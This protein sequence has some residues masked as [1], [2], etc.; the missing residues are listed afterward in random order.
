[1]YVLVLIHDALAHQL[2]L[3]KFI[4]MI[5]FSVCHGWTC[6]HEILMRFCSNKLCKPN[7]SKVL[8]ASTDCGRFGLSSFWG[9]NCIAQVENPL[10]QFQKL[11]CWKLRHDEIA[12]S[13]FRRVCWRQLRFLYL[14]RVSWL[15]LCFLSF[16]RAYTFHLFIWNLFM[17]F[18]VF[19]FFILRFLL[20]FSMN[21]IL[22]ILLNIDL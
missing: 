20:N 14:F 4:I 2:H 17:N 13:I 16:L 21:F 22:I 10:S 6:N 19:L 9:R 11:F 8:T 18:I 3:M 15:L 7:H 12:I 5:Q 1:M